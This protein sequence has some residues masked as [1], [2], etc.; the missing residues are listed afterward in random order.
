MHGTLKNGLHWC[1]SALAIAGIVF[2]VLRLREYAAAIDFSGFTLLKWSAIAALS[3]IYGLSNL[4][5][6]LA[7]RNLLRKFG[8]RTTSRWAIKTYGISQLA[9]YVPGNIFHLASRQ[10]IGMADGLPGWPLAKST[11]WELG[12]LALAGTLFGILALPLIVAN[13]PLA[14]VVIIFILMVIA[15][16]ILLGRYFTR[17]IA[18]AFALYVCFLAISSAIFVSLITLTTPLP[19]PD[20]SLW[21][22]LGGVYVIAW[23]AGFL[24]PGAPAGVGVRE[25]VLLLLLHDLVG[26]ADLLLV[27]VLGRAVTA[28][29]DGMYFALA[30][31]L[32]CRQGEAVVD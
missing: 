18:D 22:T 4:M 27:V 11:I 7:W 3:L 29:G 1:G 15:T 25:L 2:V 24:T 14:A 31:R 13:V 10:S 16:S 30:T 21:L 5:L 17:S 20:V 9:K 28:C 23:L 19:L 12:L 32:Q 6:A 8:V 26:G